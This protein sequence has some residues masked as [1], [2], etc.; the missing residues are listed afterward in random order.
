MNRT[1]C[2]YVIVRFAPFVETGEFANV[3]VLMMAPQARYFGFKLETRRYGRITRFFEELDPKAYRN[4]MKALQEELERVRDLLKAHGFDGR[5]KH[6]D[7]EFAGRLFGEVVRPRESIIRFSEVRTVLADA[8]KKK[9]EALFAYYVGR[10]FVTKERKEA[11][12]ESDVR[13]WLFDAKLGERFRR[14]EI[15]D[16]EYRA[17]FP[18]V[19]RL[20]E[21]PVKAIKPLYLG[22]DEPSRIIDHSGN[23]AQKLDELQHRRRLPDR[24]LFTVEGPGEADDRLDHA[25]RRAI[26]RLE[27]AGAVV[28]ERADRV[29]LLNFAREDVDAA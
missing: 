19:E 22:Q 4:A 26:E 20:N 18:F 8:P 7:T 23:W 29:R 21:H 24:V 13:R 25:F 27:G 14:E 1:A 15:G 17:S 5:R 16:D 6:N 28:A 10:N 3:G 2:Q 12:L 9:L 11:V